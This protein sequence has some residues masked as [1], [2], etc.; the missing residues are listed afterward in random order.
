MPADFPARIGPYDVVGEIGSGRLGI[1]YKAFDQ[2]HAR[3]VGLRVLSP[4]FLADPPRLERFRRDLRALA[5]V[6]HEN[7][8]RTLDQGEDS[9]LVYVVSEYVDGGALFDV[10]E[11][12]RLTLAEAIH[13]VRDVADALGAAHRA[14]LVHGDLN[15]RSVFVSR[16]LAVAKLGG[17]GCADPRCRRERFAP[18]RWRAR[19]SSRTCTGRPNWPAARV[20][21]PCAPTSTLWASS[22]TR[23]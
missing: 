1:V 6:G 18:P 16:D 9:G 17:F 21:P 15:P 7:L 4:E 8:L 12:S 14:G 11:R 10:L 19:A 20:R 13:V 22:P 23:R 3:V 2:A 5:A